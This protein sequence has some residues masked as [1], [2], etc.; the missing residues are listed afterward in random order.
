MYT[1][2][3]NIKDT[4]LEISG[5]VYNFEGKAPLGFVGQIVDYYITREEYVEGKITAI[6]PV[7]DN[8]VYDFSGSQVTKVSSSEIEFDDN[9]KIKVKLSDATRYIVNNRLDLKYKMSYNNINNDTIF[10][11]VDNDGDGVAELVYIYEYVNCVV[12]RVYSENNTIVLQDGYTLGKDKNIQL[13]SDKIYFEIYDSKGNLT[14]IS[15]ITE[16]AVLSIARSVKKDSIRL[17]V[18][19]DTATGDVISKSD[20]E[21]V[22]GNTAYFCA[23]TIKADEL[24]IGAHV[25]VYLNF[26]GKIAY[27]EEIESENVY[28]YVYTYNSP[29]GFGNYK[30]K[31]LM[32]TLISVKTVEGATDALTGEVS[33]SQSLFVRNSDVVVY[34]AEEKIIFNGKR[35]KTGLVLPSVLD[36][37]VAYSVNENGRIYKIDSLNAVDDI[38]IVINEA[39]P[40]KSTNLYNKVYNGKELVFG[41]GKGEPIGIQ[42]DY[43]MAFCVPKYTEDG[44]IKSNL[45]E[46]DLKVMVELK[47][48][49]GYE[50]NGYEQ[51]ENT[52]ISEV[53]VIQQIMQSGQAGMVSLSSDVALVL[54]SFKKIDDDGN[55][56]LAVKML[57]DG[58]ER[59]YI[60][61]SLVPDQG[62]FERL[63]KGD[64]IA[65]S[66]DGFD[67]LNAVDT[68]RR[69]DEY[70]D[71]NSTNKVCGEIKGIEYNRISNSKA[72][73]V[74]RVDVGFKNEDA[75][76]K[77]LEILAKSVAPIFVVETENKMRVGSMEDMQVGDRIYA[78]MNGDTIRAIV[79]KR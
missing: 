30:V 62:D 29:S 23:E 32:P 38:D 47:T 21:V 77:T 13:D 37:P 10:R 40:S 71:V 68:L 19:Y 46:D 76:V 75:T 14:D 26:L 18:C 17:V 60:V 6:E 78:A 1:E 55:E 20:D 50:V 39:L 4:Q 2:V 74:H 53:L 51:D 67:R 61:S 49:V 28:A 54:K 63:S 27:F 58:E 16:N 3:P 41:K 48:G 9:G 35:T 5:K 64:L 43:T 59:T 44:Q 15:A 34:E 33:T 12:E 11:T 42:K 73:W 7:S 8:V 72:R 70:Y 65:Y 57:A 66:L 56:V 36:K 79:I 45:N 25:N 52:L 22:I 24:K 69:I 31:L